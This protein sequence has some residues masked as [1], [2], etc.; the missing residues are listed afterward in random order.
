MTV[1]IINKSRE[2]KRVV[3]SYKKRVDFYK[4]TGGTFRKSDFL[5]QCRLLLRVSKG[6]DTPVYFPG[7]KESNRQDEIEQHPTPLLPVDTTTY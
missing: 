3:G 5:S 4:G 6:S 2:K 7:K 1:Q